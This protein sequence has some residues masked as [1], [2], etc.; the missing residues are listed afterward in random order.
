[1]AFGD[2]DETVKA[3]KQEYIDVERKILKYQY[4]NFKLQWLNKSGVYKLSYM[5]TFHESFKRNPLK[6]EIYCT[7]E[8]LLKICNHS[9]TN[10]KL[11]EFLRHQ[12]ESGEHIKPERY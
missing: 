5:V 4:L 12:I 3:V 6:R 8:M 10:Y 7:K 11:S 1:M 9:N 2:F